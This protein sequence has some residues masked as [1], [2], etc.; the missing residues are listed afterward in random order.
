MMNLPYYYR[1]KLVWKCK[2]ENKGEDKND[3]QKSKE[4]NR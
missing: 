2:K 4:N 3:N 1:K